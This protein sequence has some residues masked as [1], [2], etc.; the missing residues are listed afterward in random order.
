MTSKAALA[1]FKY[2][3]KKL[4]SLPRLKLGALQTQITCA[5]Y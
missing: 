5:Y 1:H 2:K 4:I 3:H